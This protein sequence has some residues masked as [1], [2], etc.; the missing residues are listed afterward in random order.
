MS[1]ATNIIDYAVIEKIDKAGTF[2][3][4]TDEEINMYMEHSKNIAANDTI[5]SQQL[6]TLRAQQEAAEIYINEHTNNTENVVSSIRSHR[7]SLGKVENE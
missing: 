3:G 5:I 4:F 7:V 6:N 2:Q 1:M